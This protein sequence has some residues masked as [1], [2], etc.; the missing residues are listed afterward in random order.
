M[1]Y[2]PK[3]QLVIASNVITRPN[4]AN[5]YAVGDLVANSVTAGSV[6][7]FVF[8]NVVRQTG[9]KSQVRRLG[10]QA[11]QALA[12]ALAAFRVHLFGA[13]P[14]VTN[15]DNGAIDVASNMAAHIGYYDVSLVMTGTGQGAIGWGGS[16]SGVGEISYVGNT[17]PNVWALLEARAA[18]TPTALETFKLFLE[19]YTY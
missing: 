18:Y 11:S 2:F 7:P 12:G 3:P 15:G 10:I 5:A 8:Q 19:P 14:T 1:V 16:A 9:Y 13:A 17:S 4:D 6:T